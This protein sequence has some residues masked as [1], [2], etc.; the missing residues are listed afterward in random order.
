MALSG[1]IQGKFAGTAA[2]NVKPVIEWKATQNVAKNQSTITSNLVFIKGNSYWYPFNLSGHNVTMAIGG[3]KHTASRTFDLRSKNRQVIWTRTT[4]VNHSA[5]GT[6][7]IHLSASGNTGISNIG[8]YSIG[9]TVQLNTIPR[10]STM[11]VTPTTADFG[12]VIKFNISKASGGFK[13]LINY[14]I[15][16]VGGNAVA[17]TDST[18]PTW[19]IPTD[20]IK[21]VPTS[22]SAKINLWLDTYSGSTKIGV[23]AYSITANV[24]KSIVP[25]ISSFSAKETNSRLSSFKLAANEFLQANSKIQFSSAATAGSGA[26]LS[27]STIEIV[28]VSSINSSSGI[29][30]LAPLSTH[31]GS[32]VARLTVRDSRGRTATKEF[33]ITIKGYAPPKI[34]KFEATRDG[35]NVKVNKSVT[36]SAIGSNTIT[37]LL[38]RDNGTKVGDMTHAKNDYVFGGY[39][40]EKSFVFTLKVSDSLNST[41]S[42]S[43]V[44]TGKQLMHID[45]D[46]G[47][48][49]GKYRERGVLDILGDVWINGGLDVKRGSTFHAGLKINGTATATDL[50]INKTATVGGLLKAANI[51][52]SS[53]VTVKRNLGVHGKIYASD[54][55]MLPENKYSGTGGAIDMRNSDIVG[56]N[57]IFFN[58]PTEGKGE[59]LQFP[60]GAGHDNLR[61]Y[62]GNL[63]LND[64]IVGVEN[65]K[66]VLWEGAAYM[67]GSQDITMKRNINDCPN[68]WAL[69]WVQYRN[70]KDAGYGYGWSFIH[71]K[72][73]GWGGGMYVPVNI[74][75]DAFRTKYLYVSDANKLRG[76]DGNINSGRNNV[77]LRGVYVW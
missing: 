40:Q 1:T 61:V 39:P 16:G 20:L 21:H 10:K 64:A 52:S 76:N 38:T 47:F 14:N 49:I 24:P 74:G 45:R 25:S 2:S 50:N 33:S 70:G 34:A 63:Y 41:S 58:D 19:T 75:D 62:N 73:A 4:T 72:Q 46:N 8:S 43:N 5:D 67:N 68:G 12:G 71:K 22:T 59:G 36:Y 65:V 31:S 66:Q 37:Y 32:K 57:S 3:Y 9:E 11:T 54:T 26:K 17:L 60:R 51:E 7:K 55:I 13:H 35:T 15:N 23:N 29:V 53:D 48:G 30:D 18:T 6:L 44:S 42:V 56:A 69:W 27:S 77:V 28:G